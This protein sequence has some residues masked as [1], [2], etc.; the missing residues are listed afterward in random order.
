M[1]MRTLSIV[2]ALVTSCKNSSTTSAALATA[3]AAP[4]TASGPTSGS[5]SSSPVKS[6]VV[7][8]ADVAVLPVKTDAGGDVIGVGQP[9]M[10][11][12]D[13]GPAGGLVLRARGGIVAAE[14][15]GAVSLW[16]L[17]TG[18]VVRRVEP[19]PAPNPT[20]VTFALSPDAAW[21]AV[22][23][24]SKMRV[25]S[26]PFDQV[27]FTPKCSEVRAFSHDS[28]LFACHDILPEVWS[29]AERKLVV[30]LPGAGQAQRMPLAVQ[31]SADDRSLYWATDREIMRWDFA[32]SGA[33]TSVYASQERIVN[34]AFSEGSNTAFVSTHPPGSYKHAS[35][36]VDLTNGQTAAPGGEFIAAVSAS[37][38]RLAYAAG[39]SVRVVD[40]TT[41]KVVWSANQSAIVQRVAF[42]IDADILG[43]VE[44][45]RLHVVDLASGPR[46]YDAPSRFAGWLEEGVAAIER[47]GKLEQLTL[48]DR[49]WKPA[50]RAA[51]AV[52]AGAPAWATWIAPGGTMAAE[53]SPRHEASPD[54]RSS[55]PCAPRLRVWTPKG[56]A[57]AVAT[58]CV[59]PESEDPGWDIGGG[60]VA[61]VGT[62]SAIVYDASSG[63]RVGSINV[64]RPRIDKPKFARAFWDMALSPAGNFLALVWRGPELPP[65]GNPD[66][67]EDALHIAE[68]QEKIDCVLALSGECRTEYFLAVYKLG[69]APKQVWRARLDALQAPDMRAA[70]PAALAFDHAGKHLLVGMH[71]GEIQVMSTSSSE[72][73]HVERFHHGPITKLVVSPGDG[74]VF[75]EDA[76]GQQRMWRLPR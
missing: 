6:N 20:V 25:L 43:F 56:G 21:L 18:E 73:P 5:G 76:A 46:S 2:L 1:I 74:W 63:K 35:V 55:T 52:K 65:E 53:P 24:D 26:Q 14:D 30:K 10:Q 40:A 4:A 36:L 3:S 19:L 41:G 15:A 45:K 66:P 50:D 23:S 17:A 58:T 38:K 34:V 11:L 51:L 8:H 29:V 57:K 7:S 39:T 69:G 64:E 71:D 32:S 68:S 28:K 61:A 12:A 70:Q 49:T 16:N 54:A 62:R 60:W 31:F 42:A 47:D 75:S 33:V 59:G 72:T 27:V 22:G 67:R 37:G 48:A 9:R 13:D 44:G